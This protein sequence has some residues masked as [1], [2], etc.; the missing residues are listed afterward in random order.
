M[1]ID[2]DNIWKLSSFKLGADKS[3][4]L[5]CASLSSDRFRIQFLFLRL[6]IDKFCHSIVAFIQL[7]TDCYYFS[8]W[9]N[10]ALISTAMPVQRLQPLSAL[11]AW[12]TH[13]ELQWF[14]KLFMSNI[15]AVQCVNTILLNDW[16]RII[17]CTCILELM[18]DNFIC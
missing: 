2:F 15:N 5:Y 4:I 7:W 13:H 11:L 18:R 3:L 12:R 17:R 10:K 14:N 6:L 9:P 8:L 1:K 16:L